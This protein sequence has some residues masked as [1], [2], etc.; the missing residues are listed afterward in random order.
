MDKLIHISKV[1]WGC[2]DCDGYCFSC[3]MHTA[4][5]RMYHYAQG[6]IYNYDSDSKCLICKYAGSD[7]NF[8]REVL[9][10]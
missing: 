5:T 2:K 8:K 1:P 3:P 9:L 6:I 4:V 10:Y 7:R